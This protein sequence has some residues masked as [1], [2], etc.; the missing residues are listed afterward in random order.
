MSNH[1]QNQDRLRSTVQ[2]TDIVTILR[3]TDIEE[4]IS[5]EDLVPGDLV[6]IPPGGCELTF[7][8]VLLSGSA[9]G[10]QQFR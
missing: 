3:G 5:S 7:D 4:N 9:I 2:S 10:E 1:F 8:G 6:C